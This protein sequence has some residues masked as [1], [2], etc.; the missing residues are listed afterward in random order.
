MKIKSVVLIL[1]L[2]LA[3]L[4]SSSAQLPVQAIRLNQLGFYPNAAK[5]AVLVTSADTLQRLT[6]FQLLTEKSKKVVFTG[7]LSPVRTNAISGK[8]TRL[9]D[10]STYTKAGQYILLIPGVGHS[11]SFSIGPN[12]HRALAI[13]SIKSFYYQ[14]TATDLPARYAGQWSRPA[15]HPDTNV[16]IH[17]SAASAGRPAGTVIS[18][19][20]GWYDAGDYNKYI[21]NSGITMGT[22]LS[23]CEDF[24]AYVN[25]L[26]T[27]IPESSNALPDVLDEILWN[28][29]WMLTMQDPADGGV[30]HKLTNPGFDAMIMPDKATKPRYVVQKS[31]TATLDFAAVMAQAGRLLRAYNKQLPGLADSCTSAAIQAW[32]WSV[33]NPTMAYRQQVI[34]QQVDPDISTGTYEDRDASD[35]WIWAAA[36]L[37]VTTKDDA[38]YRAVNLFPDQATPLPGWP[39]VRT[40]AYY[41]LGRFSN[42]LTDLGKK[43]LPLVKQHL[44]ILADSLIDN[45]D[46]QAF[47]TVMGKSAKDFI[48]GSSSVAAN[49]G[50]AL[51]MAYRHT[52]S[53]NRKRY[54]HHA[55]GNLDYLLGRNAVGYSF[56]T[57]FGAKT[58]MHPHHRPSVADGIVPPV[59]G[60]LSGGTNARAASQ[61][62]CAGYT[63][64]LADEVFLDADCSYASNEIAINWNA[65]LVYLV[66]AIEALQHEQ[67]T[68]Q[69]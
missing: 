15:G 65:P 53:P 60:L 31:I 13:G 4:L 19:S 36:E 68:S 17:P 37:Y 20:R 32:N 14:R 42:T 27:N 33:K 21:V 57:G 1:Y 45:T 8:K 10:F 62:K 5:I 40:L 39:Q 29:R 22:L 25:T 24:P 67:P 46:K 35:E 18:S 6:T 30:Y 41:T 26:S 54:L 59:P 7:Q 23:L 48:W 28:L 56:V 16:L 64:T 69:P 9:A 43:D 63:T 61:D 50:I 52:N 44:R 34:N 3:S 12:V 38:Y 66:A 51:L 2:L 55:L 47:A 49:Q 58:P 11:Y